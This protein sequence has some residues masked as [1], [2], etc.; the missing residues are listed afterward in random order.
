MD[1]AISH[2]EMPLSQIEIEL[3]E[4]VRAAGPFSE[5]AARSIDLRVKDWPRL[6]RTAEHHGLAPLAF[7]SIKK[8]NLLNVAPPSA[9]EALR[10][11]YMRA[12]VAN[13]FA[14]EELSQLIERLQRDS[15][16]V[17]VLKGGALALSLYDDP[18]LRPMGDVD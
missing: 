8:C 18:G 17:I 12:S 11:A 6:V 5:G 15:I 16:S 10:L 9:I 2:K 13:R 3:I 1:R 4:L 7:A 14:F